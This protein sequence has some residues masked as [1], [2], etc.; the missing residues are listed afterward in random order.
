MMIPCGRLLTRLESCLVGT[1]LGAGSSHRIERSE[2]SLHYA[3]ILHREQR[4]RMIHVH[5]KPWITRRGGVKGSTTCIGWG[6]KAKR[7]DRCAWTL[8]LAVSIFHDHYHHSVT[9]WG[10]CWPVTNKRRRQDVKRHTT[11]TGHDIKGTPAMSKSK[12]TKGTIC[13]QKVHY[14]VY[15]TNG[16]LRHKGTPR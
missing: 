3:F 9:G 8:L 2:S 5:L 7:V 11:M 4:A 12:R 15:Y 1:L 14:L 13:Q 16:K 10:S 6:A